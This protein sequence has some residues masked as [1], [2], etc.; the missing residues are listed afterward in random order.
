[1][2]KGLDHMVQAFFVFQYQSS[3]SILTEPVFRT[4][5]VNAR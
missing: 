3:S 4:K 2:Q 5:A 1:M